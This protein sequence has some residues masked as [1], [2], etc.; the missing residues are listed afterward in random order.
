MMRF[1]VD[2]CKTLRITRRTKHRVEFKYLMSTPSCETSVSH[3]PLS[4]SDSANEILAT[5]P[6]NGKFQSLE[7]INSDKYL[8][9][10]LDSK[11]TFNEHVDSICSKATRI[12]N[13]CRRNLSMCP[14]ATK[15][16]AYRTL[17]RPQLEYASTAWNPYTVKNIVKVENVQRRAARW[18]LGNYTYGPNAH[19]TEQISGQLGWQS[20]QHRRAISDL[21]MFYK[22][23]NR[24]VGMSFPSTVEQH[25]RDAWRYRAMQA[26]HSE[27]YRNG[28][29]C[30]TVRLWNRLPTVVAGSPT[31]DRFRSSMVAWVTPLAWHR[32][33]ATGVWV[34]A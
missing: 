4:T 16:I 13:L 22:I 10:I 29:Y 1:N 7:V 20:M 30:R 8:G 25:H 34:L 24:L 28:F 3:V 31:I 15:E 6:P 11:L 21:C 14:Q 23:R 9:I 19:L 12:L 27:A 32:A 5:I 17:I 33:P 18:V 26:H 2:K